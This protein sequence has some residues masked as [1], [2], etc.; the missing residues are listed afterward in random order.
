MQ[1]C[2]RGNVAILRGG[3]T[4]NQIAGQ[5]HHVRLCC[6]GAF[7]QRL[8][9]G[10]V[11]HRRC[12]NVCQ[13][14]NAQAIELGR[15]ARQGHFMLIDLWH[16]YALGQAISVQAHRQTDAQHR[17][18]WAQD[19]GSA[20]LTTGG[21]YQQPQHISHDGQHHAHA[22]GRKQATADDLQVRDQGEIQ[23]L[24]AHGQNQQRRSNTQQRGD[25]HTPHE[26][27][28]VVFEQG[29]PKPERQ[30]GREQRKQ[31]NHKTVQKTGKA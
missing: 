13:H 29:I 3:V 30:D 22:N 17:P 28:A 8:H 7:H 25:G 21:A 27:A 4:I 2:Q 15:Q 31:R 6:V 9:I 10:R 5:H 12:V 14:G 11:V 16:L 24:M 20:G 1:T 19:A 26:S 23:E 18:A